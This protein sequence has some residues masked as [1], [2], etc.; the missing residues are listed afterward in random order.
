MAYA[1]VLHG[2][3]ML[4]TDESTPTEGFTNTDE[5]APLPTWRYNVQIRIALVNDAARHGRILDALSIVFDFVQARYRET[6]LLEGNRS[7]EKTD[8]SGLDR[9]ER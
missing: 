2:E 6:L 3:L 5:S 8:G 1:M 7:K 4:Q 9:R